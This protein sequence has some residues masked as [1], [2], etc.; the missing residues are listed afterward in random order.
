MPKT[1]PFEKIPP[2]NSLEKI[3]KRS[4]DILRDF[5]KKR[6]ELV[7]RLEDAEE[8]C[9]QAKAALE[10]AENLESYDS[11]AEVLRRSETAVKFAKNGL[12]KLDAAPRMDESEYAEAVNICRGIMDAAVSSYREKAAALMDQLKAVKDEYTNTAEEINRT[13]VNLDD[14]ANILQNKYQYKIRRYHGIPDGE[15]LDNREWLKYALRYNKNTT[16]SLATDCTE[17]ERGDAPYK[18]HD[19]VLNAAWSV[20]DAAYPRCIY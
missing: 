16:Y 13:L 15:E 4:S 12:S 17:E 14:A 18:R 3:Q 1:K 5:P 9:R 10:A 8:S 19:S 20:I 6:A 7:K 2:V 11:A